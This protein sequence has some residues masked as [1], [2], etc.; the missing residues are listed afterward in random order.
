[1]HP[2]NLCI[3]FLIGPD[4]DI[5]ANRNANGYIVSDGK[6]GERVATISGS[7][8]TFGSLVKHCWAEQFGSVRRIAGLQFTGKISL[9]NKFVT[10][11][12]MKR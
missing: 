2:V 9:P 8:S 5:K 12:I 7:N 11:I 6:S 10:T 4:F 1:M 3:Q